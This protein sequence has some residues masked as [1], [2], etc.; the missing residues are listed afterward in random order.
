MD[1]DRAALQFQLDGLRRFA[2]W[3]FGDHRHRDDCR[4]ASRLAIVPSQVPRQLCTRLRLR[5]SFIA[6]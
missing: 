4:G 2:C 1:M 3:R 5:P 6:T